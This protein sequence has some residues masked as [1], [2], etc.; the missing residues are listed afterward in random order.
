[1]K[2]ITM[3]LHAW[4]G[5]TESVDDI[6]T[7]T[8]CAALSALLDRPAERP[9]VG[10]PLPPLWHWLYFLPLHRQAEIGPDGHA[11]RGGFLPPVPLPRRMW[12][13]SQFEFH[14]PLRVGD[15]IKSAAT[16]RPRR[17][18]SSTTTSSTARRGSP[19]TS[20]P[21]RRRPRPARPGSATSCPTTCC[22][23]ATPP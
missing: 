22:C 5:R 9:V 2:E 23:S 8:P 1:L 11:R 18:S 13:G 10:T 6:V 16:A 12:A 20:S 4:I 17:P 7:A 21:R 19:A 3:D 14:A 15:A